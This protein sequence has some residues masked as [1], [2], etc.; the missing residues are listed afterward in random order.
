MS[1]EYLRSKQVAQ[2]DLECIRALRESDAF[3]L[4]W[5]RRLKQKHA[6]IDD[7][8]RNHPASKVDKE[9]REILRRILKEYED[10]MG[11][12]AKDEAGARSQLEHP[13]PT[14]SGMG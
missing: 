3:N 4:Y 11:M 8:F 9:E 14:I 13:Q 1:E 10:L 12:M 2:R 7:I 5:M 6:D